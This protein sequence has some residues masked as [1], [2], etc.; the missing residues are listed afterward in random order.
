MLRPRYHKDRKFSGSRWKLPHSW[1]EDWQRDEDMSPIVIDATR[2]TDGQQVILVPEYD[3][4]PDCPLHNPFQTDIYHLGNML[5]TDF[6]EKYHG[7]DFRLL[8]T[9]ATPTRACGRR[10]ASSPRASRRSAAR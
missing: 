3:G 9:C 4:Y 8:R 1:F 7:F 10:L 6:I 5:R 2:M